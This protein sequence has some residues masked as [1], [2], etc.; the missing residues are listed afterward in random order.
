MQSSDEW[1]KAISHGAYQT[2]KSQSVLWCHG[3]CMHSN[4]KISTHW[5]LNKMATILQTTFSN[6]FSW[7]KMCAFCFRFH[8]GLLPNWQ[9]VRTGSVDGLASKRQQA[10][11]L[12]NDDLVHQYGGVTRPQWV[13]EME[14]VYSTH[15]NHHKYNKSLIAFNLNLI[16]VISQQTEVLWKYNKYILRDVMAS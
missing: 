5:G 9:Y 2:V 6:V 13:K 14:E 10:I 15:W 8:W 4:S 16:F 11:T 3:K 12:T 7:K 1:D